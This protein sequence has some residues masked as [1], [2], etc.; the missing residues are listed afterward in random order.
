MGSQQGCFSICIIQRN[1]RWL[2]KNL[3]AVTPI[4]VMIPLSVSKPESGFRIRNHWLKE[5]LDFQEKAPSDIVASI[6]KWFPSTFPQRPKQLIQGTELSRKGNPNL[7]RTFTRGLNSQWHLDTQSASS[8]WSTQLKHDQGTSLVV[9]WLR[10]CL[11]MQGT[12]VRSLVWEEST[13]CGTTKP[14]QHNY[15]NPCTQ[16]LC[17]ATREATT[18]RTPCTTTKSSLCSRRLE[19]TCTAINEYSV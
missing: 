6:K 7:L 3:K 2:I 13:C 12:Q 5:T 11:P 19:K 9:Q 15:W 16:S 18:S 10:I 8:D 1:P 17:S 4:K 14:K